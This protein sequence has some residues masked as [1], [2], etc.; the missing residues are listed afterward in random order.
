MAGYRIYWRA[1]DEPRWTQSVYVGDVT[2]HVM[3]NMV[4]DN[5]FFGVAAVGMDGSES[6]VVFPGAAGN[7]G[8]Y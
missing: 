1:T 6:P 2:T 8:G 4:I 5:W 3:K 7:F